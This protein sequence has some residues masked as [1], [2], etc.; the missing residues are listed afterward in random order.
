M[1]QKLS[2]NI[3]RNGK[4]IP[5]KVVDKLLDEEFVKNKPTVESIAITLT[6]EVPVN[7]YVDIPA[8]PTAVKPPMGRWA[9]VFDPVS[10]CDRM[11][12]RESNGY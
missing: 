2:A 4:V 1:K 6:E 11:V 9:S 7:A 12:W 3:K 5:K 8:I 10:L